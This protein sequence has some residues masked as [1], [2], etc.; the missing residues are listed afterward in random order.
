MVHAGRVFGLNRVHST[1]RSDSQ[2]WITNFRTFSFCFRA[3][4]ADRHSRSDSWFY[5]EKFIL[6]L[7]IRNRLKLPRKG[8]LCNQG[9][10]VTGAEAC[11]RHATLVTCAGTWLSETKALNESVAV[12]RAPKFPFHQVSCSHAGARS[13]AKV[14][15]AFGNRHRVL[16][17]KLIWHIWQ[18]FC[19]ISPKGLTHA[20]LLSYFCQ[21]PVL[22]TDL[23]L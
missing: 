14:R 19:P 1:G 18:L 17:W 5:F 8:R 2:L 16:R 22:F 12:L 6:S 20:C 3:R 11:S 15:N 23:F 7:L 9:G 13:T 10:S 4:I 21:R